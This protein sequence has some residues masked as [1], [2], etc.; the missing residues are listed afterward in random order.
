MLAN[1][2]LQLA[3]ETFLFIVHLLLVVH[4]SHLELYIFRLIPGQNVHQTSARLTWM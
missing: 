2:K 1:F 3:F 4:L